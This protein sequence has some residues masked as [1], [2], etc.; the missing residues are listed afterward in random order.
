MKSTVF[1]FASAAMFAVLPLCAAEVT[2]GEAREAVAGWAELQEALTG[3][4]RFSASAISGV[5]T[6]RGKDDRGAFHV[7]SFEG[8]GFAVTSGDTEITPIL[9]Y[10][11]DG[12]FAPSGD[13][14]L[15]DILVD[16]V[17]GRAKRLEECKK[18]DGESKIGG[19]AGN[20]EALECAEDENVAPV[21]AS[22]NASAWARL[23]KAATPNKSPLLTASLPRIPSV[24]DLR[25][26]PLCEAR[27]AQGKVDDANCYNYYTPSNRATGCV[28]TGMAQIMYRFKYP[29]SAIPVTDRTYSSTLDCTNEAGS[30]TNRI[31]QVFRIA[32]MLW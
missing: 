6:Y 11:E 26:A 12:E 24:S 31:S 10:S 17:A 1:A 4:T 23:R 29:A 19:G 32:G 5:A 7:V 22:A 18:E 25:V 13:N 3:G 28:A 16:D 15:W 20:Y 27:W 30:V 9:A 14:P 8:G 21:S 2:E